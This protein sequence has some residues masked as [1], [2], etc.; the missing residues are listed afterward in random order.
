MNLSV[1]LIKKLKRKRL[2]YEYCSKSKKGMLRFL[3]ILYMLLDY[4]ALGG[5]F[6]NL[7]FGVLYVVGLLLK[8]F[9]VNILLGMLA[10]WPMTILN[11]LFPLMIIGMLF[12]T[13]LDVWV[14]DP[15]LFKVT[16]K[17]RVLR[18]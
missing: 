5:F 17:Y 9:S 15:E 3:S 8:M 18:L 12:T 4:L 6:Y 16:F 7:V 1:F 13:I 10:G 2:Y 14:G 11:I